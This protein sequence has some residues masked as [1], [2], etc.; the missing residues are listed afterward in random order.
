MH[1]TL[2]G[3]VPVTSASLAGVANFDVQDMF[4]GH[5]GEGFS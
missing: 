4:D 3:T 1:Q 5:L 2:L